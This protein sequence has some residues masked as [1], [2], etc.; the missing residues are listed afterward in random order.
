MDN[1]FENWKKYNKEIFS[2]ID[3]TKIN[4]SLLRKNPSVEW[5]EAN[6][7]KLYKRNLKRIKE[8]ERIKKLFK[9][10]NRKSPH[11]GLITA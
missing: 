9:E 3:D 11:S 7:D 8:K 5:F 2:V 10:E 4:L 1:I 6:Y